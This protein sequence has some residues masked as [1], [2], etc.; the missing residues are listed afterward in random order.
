MGGR[1]QSAVPVAQLPLGDAIPV[2]AGPVGLALLY[3]ERNGGHAS[4][5]PLG[6]GTGRL[7][8]ALAARM[9]RVTGI[10]LGIVCLARPRQR[11]VP[12][13]VGPGP[14]PCS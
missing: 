12:A 6:C 10:S 3:L 4:L 11:L 2:E 8:H 1:L 9:R 5:L 7:C 13:D 14:T